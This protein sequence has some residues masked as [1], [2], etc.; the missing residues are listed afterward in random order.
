[1]DDTHLCQTSSMRRGVETENYVWLESNAGVC[2]VKMVIV[3]GLVTPSMLPRDSPFV[4]HSLSS[5]V[6]CE[7]EYTLV[8]PIGNAAP[9]Y[10]CTPLST[11][12]RRFLRRHRVCLN[13]RV[14]RRMIYYS[15]IILCRNMHHDGNQQRGD[16]VPFLEI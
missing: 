11:P 8:S 10:R 4:I 6:P 5:V 14:L 2:L 16:G 13:W 15:S 7:V 12:Y 1:M 9:P 3:M